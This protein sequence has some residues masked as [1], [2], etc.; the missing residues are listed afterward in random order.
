[1]S[2]MSILNMRS[3][4]YMRHRCSL[5]FTVGLQLITGGIN[6]IKCF[7]VNSLANGWQEV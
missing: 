5:C 7:G 3:S 6:V 1:M 2:E 4:R